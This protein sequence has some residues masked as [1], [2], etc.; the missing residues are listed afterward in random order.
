MKAIAYNIREQ[1]KKYLVKANAKKHE[2][3]FISNEL[4]S[5]TLIYSLD[6][7]VLILYSVNSMSPDLFYKLKEFGVKQIISRTD[8][9]SDEI[10]NQAREYGIFINHVHNS[11]TIEKKAQQI[12]K[13]LDR[14]LDTSV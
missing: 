7:E 8:K 3:T 4:N 11:L 14:L 9:P 5:D 10:I 13:Q 1:E 6:K 2:F 12:I